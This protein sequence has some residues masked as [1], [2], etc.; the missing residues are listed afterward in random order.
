MRLGLKA[1]AASDRALGRP[2]S[3]VARCE[4]KCLAGLTNIEERKCAGLILVLDNV[5]IREAI[6]DLLP[7]WG[8]TEADEWVN[9][10]EWLPL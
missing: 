2:H 1:H 3:R 4:D 7:I 5:P 9:R 6:E 10:M 8:L